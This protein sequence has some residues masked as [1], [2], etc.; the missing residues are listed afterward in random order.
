MDVEQRLNLAAGFLHRETAG[1]DA[2]GFTA[3]LTTAAGIPMLPAGGP[4]GPAPDSRGAP[5]GYRCTN[6]SDERGFRAELDQLLHGGEE[7]EGEGGGVDAAGL[8][9]I[10]ELTELL[11]G[12]AA[13][14]PWWHRAAQ[15]GDEL[16]AAALD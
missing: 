16:A 3:R 15:A 14:L 5:G 12:R 1:W 7:R 13:A 9:R 10:A 8:R 11:D 2:D 4:G 6:G